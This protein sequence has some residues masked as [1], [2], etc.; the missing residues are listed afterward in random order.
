MGRGRPSAQPSLVVARA[1]ENDTPRPSRFT[2]VV[3]KRDGQWIIA[4]HH[5][6]PLSA[7]RP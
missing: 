2:M 3:T 4:H 7:S 1:K 5:L 6:S